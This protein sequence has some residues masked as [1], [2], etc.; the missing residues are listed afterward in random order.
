MTSSPCLSNTFSS[1]R[2]LLASTF[3]PLFSSL[4]ESR[5]L[6]L[7]S[8]PVG[9]GGAGL[10]RYATESLDLERWILGSTVA[11]PTGPSSDRM[12]LRTASSLDLGA[13]ALDTADRAESRFCVLVGMVAVVLFPRLAMLGL[14][15]SV[16]FEVGR[17]RVVSSDWEVRSVGFFSAVNRVSVG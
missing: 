10:L 14:I 2:L 13:E 5:L 17:D 8:S 9:A 15:L 7:E 16:W 11:V 12:V 3:F 4:T 6:G 1:A